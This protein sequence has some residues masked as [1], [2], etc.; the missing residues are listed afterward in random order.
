MLIDRLFYAIIHSIE[1]P[2]SHDIKMGS[3]GLCMVVQRCCNGCMMGVL[4]HLSITN[5]WRL[6]W[7]FSL[8]LTFKDRVRPILFLCG[9][10]W[11]QYFFF[12]KGMWG[13][14]YYLYNF[15]IY[16]LN[17]KS[18]PS[19]TWKRFYRFIIYDS[20]SYFLSVLAWSLI[21]LNQHIS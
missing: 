6:N 20:N 17:S 1:K 8:K 14:C 12:F 9:D 21:L 11:E 4:S 13:W 16:K 15:D 2:E 3:A 10:L 19:V 5:Y 18:T 7:M